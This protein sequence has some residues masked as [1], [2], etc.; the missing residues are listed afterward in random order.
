M[1]LSITPIEPAFGERAIPIVFSTDDNYAPYLSVALQ[2]LLDHTNAEKL[3]DIIVLQ[4][5]LS[6]Q[7]RTLLSSQCTSYP[8]VSLRYHDVPEELKGYDFQ[9]NMLPIATYYRICA[10][11]IFAKYEKIVYLD[12]DICVLSDVGELYAATL[13]DNMVGACRDYGMM[14]LMQVK[15]WPQLR[16]YLTDTLGMANPTD[17]VN[18]GVLIFN[19]KACIEQNFTQR[20]LDV[21]SSHKTEFGDQDM[22]NEVC[23][24]TICFLDPAWNSAYRV[25]KAYVPEALYEAH[26]QGLRS[27]K[28]VHYMGGQNSKPWNSARYNEAALWW[29]YALQCPY[30][31]ALLN[32]RLHLI[33]RQLG[34]LSRKLEGYGSFWQYKRRYWKYKLLS[35]ITFGKTRRRYKQLRREM[36]AILKTIRF[37]PRRV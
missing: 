18:A 28:I 19:I 35:R 33:N 4:D 30:A 29:Q 5:G 11:G 2:S 21:I 14:R 22:L 13:G 27:P 9:L 32:R 25:D 26:L 36:K 17:Y 7:H 23:Q 1:S 34:E 6:E 15:E 16:S 24:G 31:G 37:A 8:N 3:Y 10:P 20:M 12:V